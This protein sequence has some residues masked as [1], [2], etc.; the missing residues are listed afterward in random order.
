ME[1]AAAVFVED[2][3]NAS[4]VRA[5]VP[6][7]D[8]P[9]RLGNYGCVLAICQID[10]NQA[11]KLRIPIGCDENPF[12]IF[13]EARSRIG[14]FLSAFTGPGC[15][16][17]AFAALGVEQPKIAFVDRN[18]LDHQK[19]LAVWRPILD[20]PTAAFYFCQHLVAFQIGR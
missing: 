17:L 13:G 1:S 20:I 5:E 8:V 11:L 16:F 2:I 12:A 10:I 7:V 9:F 6:I 4:A 3:C 15:E 19:L 14:D 18:L